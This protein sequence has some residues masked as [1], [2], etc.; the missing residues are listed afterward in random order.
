LAGAGELLLLTL[1]LRVLCLQIGE[2]LLQPGPPGERLAR[3][4][5]P[6]DLESAWVFSWVACN[7]T[8]FRLVATSA[9]PRRTFC[10]SSS[11]R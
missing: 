2:L 3:Q 4:V 9:T 10:S 5:L 8:R 6:T 7:S 11:C 1:Q